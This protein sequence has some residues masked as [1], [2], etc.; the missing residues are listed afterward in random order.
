MEASETPPPSKAD[1]LAPSSR[2]RPRSPI[3]EII[4]EMRDLS[5]VELADVQKFVQRIRSARGERPSPEL[6]TQ[7]VATLNRLHERYRASVPIS[8]VRAELASVPRASLDQAL[9]EAEARHLL[10]MEPVTLP[11]SFVEV[12]A[13][14]QHERGLLY[15]IVPFS[16]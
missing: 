8:L 1:A 11:A 10:R 4:D 13:G 9:L 6:L 16:A 15:W 5:F 12:G 14:I 7:L 2:S 3:A